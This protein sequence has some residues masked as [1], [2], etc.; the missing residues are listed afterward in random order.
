MILQDPATKHHAR[1]RA[2]K[3]RGE[4]KARAT[5]Q[6]IKSIHARE[7]TFE[8]LTNEIVTRASR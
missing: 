3:L 1:T 6:E 8:Q 7:K 5:P 4:I 2:E